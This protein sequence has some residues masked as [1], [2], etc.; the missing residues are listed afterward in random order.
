MLNLFNG[1]LIEDKHE[2]YESLS[3]LSNKSDES[4]G[5]FFEDET[6]IVDKKLIIQI[7]SWD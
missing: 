2:S 7:K 5:T 6:G 1:T 3:I 4:I